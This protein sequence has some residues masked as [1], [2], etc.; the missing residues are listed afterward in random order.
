MRHSITYHTTSRWHL[1]YEHCDVRPHTH[2]RRGSLGVSIYQTTHTQQEKF[3]R[4][5]YLSDHRHTTICQTTHTQLSVRPHRHSRRGSLG[6]S[7]CQT[8][9]THTAGEVLYSAFANRE[10]H[11]LLY[12]SIISDDFQHCMLFNRNDL[13]SYSGSEIWAS[14]SINHFF[15]FLM[16]K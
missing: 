6:V 13:C 8:T 7:I 11:S 16:T 5:E 2:S 4:G 15:P 14:F 3:S 1:R 12:M 10:P 9:H